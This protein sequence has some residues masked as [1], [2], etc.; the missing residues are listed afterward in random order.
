MST[1]RPVLAGDL[2]E[3]RSFVTD[4][5]VGWLAEMSVEGLATA[6]CKIAAHSDLDS[7]SRHCRALGDSVLNWDTEFKLV[8][9][10]VFGRPDA[11]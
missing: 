4:N 1:G 2:P 5:H 3:N 8:M 11:L 6:L 7:I 10:L 9:D